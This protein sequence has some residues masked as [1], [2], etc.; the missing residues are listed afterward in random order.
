MRHEKE[1]PM[2]KIIQLPL[3]LRDSFSPLMVDSAQVDALPL[4]IRK[5]PLS[6]ARRALQHQFQEKALVVRRQIKRYCPQY[7]PIRHD[8]QFDFCTDCDSGQTQYP[9]RGELCLTCSLFC[10]DP[11]PYGLV[12]PSAPRLALAQVSV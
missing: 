4:K 3:I 2:G 11:E 6:P 8:G 10:A 5:M 9:R 1:S 7:Q 12:L